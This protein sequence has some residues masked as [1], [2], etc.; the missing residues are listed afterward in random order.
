MMRWT[1]THL[2]IL[3]HQNVKDAA[4]LTLLQEF[5]STPL[6][7]YIS[8]HPRLSWLQ[9]GPVYA[10]PEEPRDFW[11]F[12]FQFDH[13]VRSNDFDSACFMLPYL[14]SMDISENTIESLSEYIYHLCQNVNFKWSIS[15]LHQVQNICSS[16][17]LL[18]EKFT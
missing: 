2:P 17:Y 1:V 14:N 15:K 13:A 9:Q 16:L 7:S 4:M 18:S 8:L 12:P 5:F 10:K 3:N 11:A 6:A